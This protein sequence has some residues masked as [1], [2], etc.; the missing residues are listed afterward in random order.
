MNSCSWMT[1]AG[2]CRIAHSLSTTLSH[3]DHH[4]LKGILFLFSF[5]IPAEILNEERFGNFDRG[6]RSENFLKLKESPSNH[7]KCRL[8]LRSLH[9]SKIHS[10]AGLKSSRV[11]CPSTVWLSFELSEA[12]VSTWG[13]YDLDSETFSQ[14]SRILRCPQ[15]NAWPAIYLH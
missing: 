15:I 14:S 12:W 4:R 9:L 6:I 8:V 5:A 2:S 3:L 13:G 7:K 1:E 11:P 10:S